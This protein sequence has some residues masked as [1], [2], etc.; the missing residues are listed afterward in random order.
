[1]SFL[2]RYKEKVTSGQMVKQTACDTGAGDGEAT[3]PDWNRSGD[4]GRYCVKRLIE[5]LFI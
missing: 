1:M 3:F 5:L 4:I 2:H